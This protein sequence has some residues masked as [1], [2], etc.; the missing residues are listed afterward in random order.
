MWLGHGLGA[1]WTPTTVVALSSHWSP[2]SLHN[3]YLD[4][5]AELG[6]TGMAVIGLCFMV[7]ARN[8]WRLMKYPGD[9]EIGLALLVMYA[10]LLVINAFASVLEVFNYFPVTAMLV[11]SFFVSRRLGMLE[12][13]VKP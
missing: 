8:A 11:Y 13:E 5:V 3:G 12:F 6:L 2:T 1:F 10:S 7:S 4:T 9:R